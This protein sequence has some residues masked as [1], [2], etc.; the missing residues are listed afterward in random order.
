VTAQLRD[1]RRLPFYARGAD[2]YASKPLTLPVDEG[3][4]FRVEAL[5][6]GQPYDV[7]IVED[8]AAIIDH[9]AKGLV[10]GPGEAKD[11]GDV[12]VKSR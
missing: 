11:L 5:L 3:G 4:R 7:E 1:D 8:Q 6:P 9:A 10:L 2:G 12:V